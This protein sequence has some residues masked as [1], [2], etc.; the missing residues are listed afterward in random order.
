MKLNAVVVL[1]FLE[2]VDITKQTEKAIKENFL[3]TNM[4]DFPFGD[5]KTSEFISGV[6]IIFFI[7]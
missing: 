1:E 6:F 3:V 5:S 7:K 4:R 2:V